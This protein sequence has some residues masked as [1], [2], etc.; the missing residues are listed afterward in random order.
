MKLVNP[1]QIF[2]ITRVRFLDEKLNEDRD[3][4]ESN[5]DP[6]K[7]GDSIMKVNFA[8]GNLPDYSDFNYNEDGKFL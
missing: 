5:L 1:E 4:L 6:V 8:R 3:F 7:F 2:D